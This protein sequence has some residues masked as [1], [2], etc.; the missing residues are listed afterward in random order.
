[1]VT[2][3]DLSEST[4]KQ[5]WRRTCSRPTST[6]ERSSW[7]RR[8]N[9][10]IQ[11]YLLIYGHTGYQ[12][13]HPIN[14]ATAEAIVPLLLYFTHI[15]YIFLSSCMCVMNHNWSATKQRLHPQSVAEISHHSVL[16]GD[17]IR[18]CET[19]S[20]LTTKVQHLTGS[21]TSLWKVPYHSVSYTDDHHWSTVLK[22]CFHC[23]PMWY[24][25]G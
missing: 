11:T 6:T 20:T 22:V 8:Q 24:G 18:Q 3:P 5:H 10:N 23:S 9:I 12:S 13:W 7:L 2:G 19:S 17:R 15:T 25:L 1:M 14:T 21:V 4:F 16:S